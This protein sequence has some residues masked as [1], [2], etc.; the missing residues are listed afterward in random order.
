MKKLVLIICL[1]V[2]S[3]MGMS[4]QKVRFE[5][6]GVRNNKGNILIMV[7][8]QTNAAPVYSMSKANRGK[9]ITEMDHIIKG[10]YELSVFHD[11]NDNKQLD[12][13]EQQA[14]I[15]GYARKKI[16][17]MEQDSVTVVKMKLYYPVAE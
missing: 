3:F 8:T 5:I 11:E 7:R 4:A 15:E 1:S 2:S 14:P 16:H 10:D 9:V 12:M 6:S 13:G 17:I